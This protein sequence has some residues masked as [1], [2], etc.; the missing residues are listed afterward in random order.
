MSKEK[1]WS[2]EPTTLSKRDMAIRQFLTNAVLI[3]ACLVVIYP[4]LWVV[5]MALT[6][7]ELA[8][9]SPSPIPEQVTLDNFKMVIFNQDNDGHYLF[10]HQLFLFYV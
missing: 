6:P 4:V 10:F 7:N 3:I 2:D 9:L 1:Q 8:G 5:K